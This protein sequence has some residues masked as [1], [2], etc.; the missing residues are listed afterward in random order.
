MRITSIEVK[1]LLSFD[2]DGVDLKLDPHL[3]VL[4]GPNGSGKTN[5]V[6]ALNLVMA[7]L[8]WADDPRMNT[9][10]GILLSEMLKSHAEARHQYSLDDR[11]SVRVGIELTVDW[12]K[13]L[14]VS[15]LRSA[16]VSILLLDQGLSLPKE[17]LSNWAL[18]SITLDKLE[19]LFCGSIIVEHVGSPYTPWLTAFEFSLDESRKYRWI[20]PGG[21]SQSGII[22]LF[23]TSLRETSRSAKE[24][25]YARLVNPLPDSKSVVVGELLSEFDLE[26][27]LPEDSDDIIEIGL[28]AAS[29]SFDPEMAEYRQFAFQAGIQGSSSWPG[30]NFSIARVLRLIVDRQVVIAGEQLRGIGTGGISPRS[31]GQYS[32]PELGGKPPRREPY[33]LPLRLFQL[34]NGNRQ[35]RDRFQSI[36]NTFSRLAHGR[37]FDIHFDSELA[38]SQTVNATS[39]QRSPDPITNSLSQIQQSNRGDIQPNADTQVSQAPKVSVT[40]VVFAT[41]GTT[42][43]S[44]LPIQ[45]SGAGVWESLVLADAITD[46]EDSVVILDEPALNLHPTWQRVLGN[47]LKECAGQFILV[48]HSPNLVPLEREGDLKSLVRFDR[49]NGRTSAHQAKRGFDPDM[50]RKITKEFG[51]SSEARSLLFAKGVILL[52][53]ETELGALPIWFRDSQSARQHGDPGTLDLAFYSVDGN[54]NFKTYVAMLDALSI[55]WVVVCDGA[56]FDTDQPRIL[57]FTQVIGAGVCA[58]EL[59]QF[60]DTELRSGNTSKKMSNEMFERER[61]LAARHG[62]FT[63]ANG[64]QTRINEALSTGDESFEFFLNRVLP[65]RLAK[66]F[67]E[68]GA[69]KVRK[70]RWVAENNPCPEEVDALYGSIISA[71][72]DRGMP[73]VGF[74]EGISS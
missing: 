73:V 7:A 18:N 10:E 16:L 57:I 23:A 27:M 59:K 22:Q 41:D 17:L 44:D 25:M 36:R 38:L 64:W 53:G 55:P 8:A 6:R 40:V 71:L 50:A 35:E 52:E 68:V 13:E 29:G 51:Y 56:S 70:G 63:L 37:S 12:E 3:T 32:W 9:A 46:A 33:A 19:P 30:R 60:C 49:L 24:T 39:L 1:N 65:G 34:K 5:V 31:A 61:E 11:A 20:M 43:S 26:S 74:G 58:P 14:V 21:R 48:T 15:Y 2:S 62:I 47:R 72:R 69:S 28:Y 67:V 66:A 42:Q 45:L 54:K 4:V